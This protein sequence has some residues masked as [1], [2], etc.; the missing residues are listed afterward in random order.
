MLAPL[1]AARAWRKSSTADSLFPLARRADFV[2]RY[3]ALLA[4]TVGELRRLLGVPEEGLVSGPQGLHAY[5]PKPVAV[6]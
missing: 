2:A 1:R 4:M 6:A 5:A 3:E